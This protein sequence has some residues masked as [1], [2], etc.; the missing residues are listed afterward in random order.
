MLCSAYVRLHWRSTRSHRPLFVGLELRI[1]LV[2][3]SHVRTDVL[4]SRDRQ[5]E[6]RRLV[7]RAAATGAAS[8]VL[9]L[10]VGRAAATWAAVRVLRLLVGRAAAAP[11]RPRLPSRTFEPAETP[12][13]PVRANEARSPRQPD[14]AGRPRSPDGHALSTPR[15]QTTRP[16]SPGRGS[17]SAVIGR[18]P[19][20]ARRPR[21]TTPDSGDETRRGGPRPIDR[22]EPGQG[23]PTGRPGRSPACRP[24][25]STDRPRGGAPRT[26]RGA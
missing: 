17:G 14:R 7:G 26:I 12:R 4:A 18:A 5:L 13:P 20:R 2:I 6:A 24:P 22:H 23:V 10:L 19:L 25:A 15:A 11:T 1:A 21:P 8:R 16:G 3:E 9:R